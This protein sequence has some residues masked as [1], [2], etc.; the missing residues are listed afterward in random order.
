[1][2]KNVG[3]SLLET[4]VILRLQYAFKCKVPNEGGKGK[5][6]RGLVSFY[7]DLKQNKIFAYKT[8]CEV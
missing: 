4:F 5:F 3:S 6:W 8:M 2:Y 7:Y 1:M